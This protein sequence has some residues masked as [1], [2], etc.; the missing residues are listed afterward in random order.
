VQWDEL[1]F[2][3]DAIGA[4]GALVGV[5]PAGRMYRLEPLHVKLRTD[6]L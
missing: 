2:E 6:S 4:L 5:S 3:M 1:L